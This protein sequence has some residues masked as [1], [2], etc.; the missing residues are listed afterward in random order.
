MFVCSSNAVIPLKFAPFSFYISLSLQSSLSHSSFPPHLRTYLFLSFLLFILLSPSFLF[1]CYLS[2]LHSPSIT[3]QLALS[4]FVYLT[5]FP[6]SLSPYP[7]CD[8][9]CQ[10]IF[11]HLAFRVV[12]QKRWDIILF[13]SCYQLALPVA[14]HLCY[15]W[16]Q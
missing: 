5:V 8:N 15:Q 4:R 7:S 9:L 1:S 12:R 6:V 10:L 2:L 3:L 14:F 16:Q 11:C 13:T